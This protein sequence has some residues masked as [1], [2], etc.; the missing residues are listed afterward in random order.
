MMATEVLAKFSGKLSD[1]EYRDGHAAVYVIVTAGLE[2]IEIQATRQL[3]RT[4][5]SLN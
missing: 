3:R 5:P 2:A 4:V 1:D